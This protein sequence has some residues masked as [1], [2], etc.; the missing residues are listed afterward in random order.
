MTLSFCIFL[1]WLFL[2]LERPSFVKRPSNLAV[3]VDDSAEFK[4][5]ARGD[6]V[7]TVRWRKDDG[8]LPKSRYEWEFIGR[9]HL[10]GI[11]MVLIWPLFTYKPLEWFS[12]DSDLLGPDTVTE[13]IRIR[14]LPCFLWEFQIRLYI[15]D[16][17]LLRNPCKMCYS[18]NS[19]LFVQPD[20]S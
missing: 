4:C 16:P 5:E 19:F 12:L 1:R 14:R 2:I 11:A 17:N 18:L 20:Y 8:E 9:I 3:T 15:H 10:P 13:I 7:P 6:P